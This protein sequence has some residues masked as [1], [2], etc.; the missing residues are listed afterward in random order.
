MDSI[1]PA[2]RTTVLSRTWFNEETFTLCCTR[3]QGFTCLAGQYVALGVRGEVREYTLISSPD[4]QE[5]RFLIKRVVGGALSTVL[6][7]IAP[8]DVLEMGHAKGYLTFR[9]TDRPVYFVATGVG[10]AP[11]IAMAADG[12]RGFHLLHGARNE[13]GLFY[14]QELIAAARQYI[15]CL[16]GKDRS[17]DAVPGLFRGYVTDY[18]KANLQG[19]P[20]DF[21]LCGSMAMIRDVTHHLDRHHPG[22]RIYS[23]AYD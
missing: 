2:Y 19:G 16:S 5:L 4:A 17:S 7:N 8:G 13:E 20:F 14:R 10:I 18:L 6:A 22:T 23:E 9:P 11:F 12:V 15:P 21:Y 1:S 3:P